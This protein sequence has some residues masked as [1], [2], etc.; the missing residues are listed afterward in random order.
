MNPLLRTF[1]RLCLNASPCSTSQEVL[2]AASIQV[3]DSSR[4]EIHTTSYPQSVTQQIS[5]SGFG[6]SETRVRAAYPPHLVNPK[7]CLDFVRGSSAYMS[8][9]TEAPPDVQGICLILF[10]RSICSSR[11]QQ[12]SREIESCLYSILEDLCNMMCWQ[13]EIS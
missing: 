9:L 11:L 12:Y 13:K 1:G 5:K 3:E 2:S 6:T 10:S 8:T 4:R 7:S